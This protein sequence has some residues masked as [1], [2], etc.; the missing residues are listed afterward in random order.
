MSESAAGKVDHDRPSR[1]RRLASALTFPVIYNTS[2]GAGTLLI[3]I[4]IGMHDLGAG[5]ALGG[6]VMVGLAIFGA[7]VRARKVD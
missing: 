7:Q 4:G 2:V 1:L 6:A 5:L 3:T